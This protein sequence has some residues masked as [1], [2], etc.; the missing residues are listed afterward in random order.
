MRNTTVNDNYQLGPFERMLNDSVQL[1]AHNFDFFKVRCFTMDPKLV[2]NAILL[3]KKFKKKTRF[4][5]FK[6]VNTKLVIYEYVHFV[7]RKLKEN[8]S[9]DD[10]KFNVMILVL[11]GVSLSSFKRALPKTLNY[12]KWFKRQFFLFEKHHVTGENTFQNLVP[13]LTNL[14]YKQIRLFS[15]KQVQNFTINSYNNTVNVTSKMVTTK[16]A[17]IE[18][19]FDDVPFI[20]KEFKKRYVRC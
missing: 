6:H 15:K 16:K 14:N 11:D 1:D 9:P 12:L 19:P 20:W 17:E 5:Q 7:T 8:V 13:L 2:K 3:K 10:S 4:N 18:P